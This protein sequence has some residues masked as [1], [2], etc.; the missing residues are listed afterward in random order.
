MY[1]APLSNVVWRFEW[2][3]LELIWPTDSWDTASFMSVQR[4]VPTAERKLIGSPVDRL[5]E[6]HFYSFTVI[7]RAPLNVAFCCRRHFASQLSP[8]TAECEFGLNIK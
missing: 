1:T 4:H 2:A 5:T 3:E 6:L 7:I 8:V